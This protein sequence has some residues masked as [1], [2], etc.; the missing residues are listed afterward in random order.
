VFIDSNSVVLQMME[1]DS[2]TRRLAD[3]A[4]KPVIG[5]SVCGRNDFASHDVARYPTIRRDRRAANN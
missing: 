5:A 2:L 3:H 4:Q 1:A